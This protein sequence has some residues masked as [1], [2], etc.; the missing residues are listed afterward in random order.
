MRDDK[1][2]DI[3]GLRIA[4]Q[5]KRSRRNLDREINAI[6]GLSLLK[7]TAE[8]RKKKLSHQGH[9]GREELEQIG[10]S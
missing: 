5:T 10:L 1:Q 3:T 2:I 6:S 9:V 7:V 8:D 4:W